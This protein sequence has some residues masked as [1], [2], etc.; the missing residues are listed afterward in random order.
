MV[1]R[2]ISSS[3]V[4]R[5][6]KSWLTANLSVAKVVSALSGLTSN[7]G[8]PA[9]HVLSPINVRTSAWV[10]MTEY[11]SAGFAVLALD[12]VAQ[13][14]A[15]VAAPTSSPTRRANLVKLQDRHERL[16]R[17]LHRT[18]PLHPP[19]AFLLLLQQFAFARHVAAVALGEHVLAHRRDRL[20]GDHLTADGRLY[21]HLVQLARD[22]RLQL[23]RKAAA[24]RLRLG[25]MC[26]DGK[27]VHSLAGDEDV[28]LHQLALAK[29]DHL[30]VHRGVALGARLQL[31]VEVVDDLGERNLVLENDPVARPVLEVLELAAPVLAELHHRADVGRRLD[32][33]ELHEG[34]GD[35]LDHRRVRQQ[36]R[37]VDLHYSATFQVDL[38][39]DGRR[40]RDQVQLEFALQA[41][42]H[43]LEVKQAEESAAEAEAQRGRVLGLVAQR[44]VVEL[45]LL[46]RFLEVGE[47]V[48]VGREEPG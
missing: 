44:R 17:D 5:G 26:D 2:A 30:V 20:A 24:L 31:V 34:L 11:R 18:H 15:I 28:D 46:Q 1:Y 22:D 9:H 10:G 14:E 43:D 25:A 4:P 7:D 13:A 32:D 39:L 8:A 33:A 6:M 29:A 23:L 36:G 45:Q 40:G 16:L 48:G 27:R 12:E 38:V 41:F 47:L 35:G 19:F 37:V 42:L 3:A 21:R